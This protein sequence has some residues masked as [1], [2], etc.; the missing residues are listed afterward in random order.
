MAYRVAGATEWYL[1]NFELTRAHLGQT[2]SMFDPQR[3]RD[4]TYRFGQD[5]GVTAMVF[6]AL[7]LWP[8]GET[9]RARRIGEEMLARAVASDHMLTTVFGHFQYALLHVA[10]RDAATT[11][12]LA[13]AVVKLA[14][15]YGMP[16]YG[17][18]GEFLQP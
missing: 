1:G 12:P 14:R 10:K 18:Y 11:A 15:D 9:D 3:D 7:A 5:M 8:L 13:E 16:L 2:L 6:L 4:L 17:A